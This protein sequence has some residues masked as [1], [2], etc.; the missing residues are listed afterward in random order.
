MYCT[1]Y[2]CQIVTKI[3]FFPTDFWKLN[4]KFVKIRSVGAEFFHAD[5]HDDLIVTFW[6]FANAAEKF[7]TF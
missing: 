4:I 7:D 1:H 2:S 6:N 3:E 5:T